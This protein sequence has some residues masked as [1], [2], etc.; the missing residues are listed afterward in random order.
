MGE[1]EAGGTPVCRE[2]VGFQGCCLLSAEKKAVNKL[3]G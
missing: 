2:T 3:C 1:A